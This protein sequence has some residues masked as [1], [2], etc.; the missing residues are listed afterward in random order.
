MT[1]KTIFI[2]AALN[3]WFIHK[4]NMKSTFTQNKLLENIYV[5]Q[6]ERFID[7]KYSNRVFKLNKALYDLKQSV[8]VWYD[9]LSKELKTLEFIQLNSDNCIY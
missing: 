7:K 3:N 4:I 6:P 2:L 9:T 8:R 1:Y 5:N